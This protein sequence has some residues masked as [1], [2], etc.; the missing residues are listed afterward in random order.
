MAICTRMW[1]AASGANIK[2]YMRAD[3]RS[4]FSYIDRLGFPH[5]ATAGD[6]QN[7]IRLL[8]ME[9]IYER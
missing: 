1:K 5:F 9:F 4:E 8:G 2:E 6:A 7:M 3:G